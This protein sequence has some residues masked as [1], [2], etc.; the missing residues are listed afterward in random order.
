MSTSQIWLKSEK[1]NGTLRDDIIRDLY[2]EMRKM[3][4]SSIFWAITRRKLV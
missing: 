4:N 1:V 2:K 3:L